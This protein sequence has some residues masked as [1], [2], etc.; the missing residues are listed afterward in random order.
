LASFRGLFLKATC[1][2]GGFFTVPEPF[3]PEPCETY[4]REDCEYWAAVLKQI[5]HEAYTNPDIV[6]NA[7]HNS[8]IHQLNKENLD[9][10]EKW[11]M[12]WRAYQRKWKGKIR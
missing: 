7:P 4:S 1:S 12:T 10:P 3:T 11:A 5:S 2:A 9:N 8:S 6:R